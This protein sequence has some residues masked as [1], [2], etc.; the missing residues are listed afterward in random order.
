MLGR[1]RGCGFAGIEQQVDPG[2]L[3]VGLHAGAV[4]A[5][6]IGPFAPR[7]ELHFLPEAAFVD[8]R[9]IVLETVLAGGV[10][11]QQVHA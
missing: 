4:D 7:P 8:A 6:I 3:A 10:L 11:L 2:V 1:V 9:V 5:R